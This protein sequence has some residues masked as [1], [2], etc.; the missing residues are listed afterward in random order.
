MEQYKMQIANSVG[1]SLWET[2]WEGKTKAKHAV[3]QHIPYIVAKRITTY[4]G[5]EM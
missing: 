1:Y 3:R 5:G 2:H 4:A